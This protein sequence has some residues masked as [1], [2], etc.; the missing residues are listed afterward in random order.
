MNREKF[1]YAFISRDYNKKV[2]TKPIASLYQANKELDKLQSGFTKVKLKIG[3][4][5][6]DTYGNEET[7]WQ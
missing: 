7:L 4:V 6:I 3:R 1:L 5:I 2:L